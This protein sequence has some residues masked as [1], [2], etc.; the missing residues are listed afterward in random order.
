MKALFT[1]ALL[2]FAALA[3]AS[4]DNSFDDWRRACA[5][6]HNESCSEENENPGPCTARIDCVKHVCLP[7]NV[8]SCADDPT[9]SWCEDIDC[10]EVSH[11]SRQKRN[12]IG[13]ISF[14]E[15]NPRFFGF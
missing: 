10:T 12:A 7:G 2:I 15:K 4:N 11:V 1:T 5:Y 6:L 3:A 9:L 8:G 14:D 13:V